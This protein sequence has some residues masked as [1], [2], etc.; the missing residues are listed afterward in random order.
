[1]RETK[2]LVSAILSIIHPVQFLHG[3]AVHE[4]LSDTEPYADVMAQWASCFTTMQ[5]VKN[6]A[7]PPH[8]DTRAPY[9]ALEI[10][11]AIGQYQGGWIHLTNCPY[12]FRLSLGSILAFAA[13]L[14]EH[15]VRPYKGNRISLEWRVND[16]V[17]HWAHIPQ[18]PWAYENNVMTGLETHSRT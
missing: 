9:S 4:V 15:K 17:F 7:I 12:D 11:T 13:R 1:M 3:M 16:D 5:V 14:L 8:R 10:I 2:A 6:N 18:I